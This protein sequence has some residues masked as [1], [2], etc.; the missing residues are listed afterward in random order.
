LKSLRVAT[1]LNGQADAK[2]HVT[3]FGVAVGIDELA[4]KYTRTDS[5]KLRIRNAKECRWVPIAK[6]TGVALVS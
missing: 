3:D 5:M 4:D 1:F 2:G 6:F